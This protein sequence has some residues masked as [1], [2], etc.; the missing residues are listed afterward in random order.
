MTS[1][2]K[3]GQLRA[4]RG[5]AKN[6][7]EWRRRQEVESNICANVP[8]KVG[9]ISS[10]IQQHE[11]HKTNIVSAPHRA[12][13]TRVPSVAVQNCFLLNK[14]RC[15]LHAMPLWFANCTYCNYLGQLG[16]VS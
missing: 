1:V 3:N 5:A 4:Y 16:R 15:R 6:V 8:G 7:V 13:F 2:A 10:H 11:A 9:Q 14:I 12:K